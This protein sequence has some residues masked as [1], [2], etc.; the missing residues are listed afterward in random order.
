M[1]G[2]SALYFPYAQTRLETLKE[3]VLY[4]DE[5]YCIVP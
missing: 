3:A 5:I 2:L 1:A 4:F